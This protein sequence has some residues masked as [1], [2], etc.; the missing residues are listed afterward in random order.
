V[1]GSG[2]G[3]DDQVPGLL[4]LPPASVRIMLPVSISCTKPWSLGDPPAFV[5]IKAMMSPTEEKGPVRTSMSQSV[6][7]PPAFVVTM[8]EGPG[9]AL[10]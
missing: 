3:A 1:D 7:S 8:K 9:L 2:I 6:I 4:R 10:V 5:L